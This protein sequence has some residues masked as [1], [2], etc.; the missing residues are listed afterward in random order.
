MPVQTWVCPN[1]SVTIPDQYHPSYKAILACPDCSSV[2]EKSWARDSRSLFVPFTATDGSRTEL[3][4]LS[5]VR[6]Y[7]RET[8]RQ[9]NDGVGQRIVFREYSQNSSN[10]DVNTLAKEGVQQKLPS[11]KP[12]V[13]PRSP[14]TGA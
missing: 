1:D 3:R 2:M 11:R 9:A 7:E 8:E 10:R 4:S 6:R 14:T 12:N 5:D 13:R